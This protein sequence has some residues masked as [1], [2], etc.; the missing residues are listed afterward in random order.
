MRRFRVASLL[1]VCLTALVFVPSAAALR[2]TDNSYYVPIGYVD[3]YYTH[4][5][6]GEGGCGPALPYSFTVLA[7]ALPPG[8]VL[9]DNGNVIGIP[10]QA[11]TW[12]FWV[13]LSDEDPP[14]AEWC[15]PGASERLFT[16]TVRPGLGI[17][18][19]SQRV[20]VAGRPF[21][22]Q[23]TSGGGGPQTWSVWAGSPPAGITLSRD[24]LLSGTPTV[25]GSSTFIV[26]VAI[27][28]RTATQTLTLTVV[29][30]L[31]V[32]DVKV[33]GAEVGRPFTLQLAATGGRGA[34]TW[35]LAE[36]ATL[37]D[38]L[39]LDGTGG[40]ISGTPTVAGV[41]P[42]HLTVTDAVG[43]SGTADF[44][45]TV[46]RKLALVDKRLPSARVRK[47]YRARTVA[48]GGIGPVRWKLHGRLPPGVELGTETGVLSGVPRG[49][50]VFRVSVEATDALDASATRTF[51][52]RVL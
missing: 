46:A 15:T 30:A 22:L 3:E 11:G 44:D 2:F 48:V 27:G 45:L 28:D 25:P 17:Q 26:Q 10:Q 18:Q 38:S 36:G 32:A 29:E 4:Q 41:F 14:S 52:L 43:S 33:P 12:S 6:E 24:G 1:L 9:G 19:Q 20:L 50:G 7:G 23:L 16:I 21:S 39:T 37:P 47:H 5:F 42:L 34:R 49:A 8:L 31:E 35:S 51:V 13:E 40:V